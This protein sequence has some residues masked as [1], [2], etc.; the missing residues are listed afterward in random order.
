MEDN[1]FFG[2][3]N[4]Q[5]NKTLQIETMVVAPLR[6]T[7]LFKS[8]TLEEALS[9]ISQRLNLCFWNL[10]TIENR[11]SLQANYKMAKCFLINNTTQGLFWIT[12]PYSCKH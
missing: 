4:T 6:V 12:K 5:K 11:K 1:P 2:Q 8:I 9:Y 7:L 10:S 3:L